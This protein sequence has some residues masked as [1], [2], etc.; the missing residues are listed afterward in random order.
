MSSNELVALN[1]RNIR[2]AI[3]DYG[4]HTTQT[5]VLSD[6]SDSF[7]ER[8][9]RYSV[10][11][12]GDLYRLLSQSS[13]WNE[14][15]QA[16][17]INGTRTH[18]PDYRKIHSWM[19][20]IL[21]D[22]I[23]R[24][25]DAT[26]EK[27]Y[28]AMRF[29]DSPDLDLTGSIAAIKELAPKA[30]RA[31]K[32]KSRVFKALC[33]ALSVTD[34]THGSEFQRYFAML[35]DEL[36]GRKIDFKLYLSINPAHFISMSNPKCDERGSTLTSCHS[37]NSTEYPYNCGCVGYAL[38]NVTITTLMTWLVLMIAIGFATVA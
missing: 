27:I 38:D 22:L 7:I 18:D 28:T 33:D 20:C 11:A 14:E 31:N 32:K 15:L 3:A 34:E 4:A 2:K 16:L 13:V 12:K 37:F 30:Y 10:F 29:F 26:R 5:D 1:V 21:N 19:Y 36:N 23:T 17:V 6:V 9:A 8:L 24:T 25:D 35:A